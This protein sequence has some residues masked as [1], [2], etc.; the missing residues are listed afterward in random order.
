MLRRYNRLLVAIY[1]AADT[2]SARRGVRPRVSHPV[3]QR[4]DGRHARP[5]AA[6]R[7]SVDRAVHRA[8]RAAGLPA[9]G[10]LPAAARPHARRRLLRRA[11]RQRPRGDRRRRRARSCIQAYYADPALKAIG[12]FEVSRGVWVLFLALNVVFTYTS[13][14]VV[15]DLLRRRWRAGIGLKRVLIVGVGDLGRMVA[16]RILE[17]SELGFQLVGFVDDRAASTDAIGYRGLPLLGTVDQTPDICAQR[18]DRRDLRRAA[19]RRARQDARRRR[20]RDAASAS[21]CTSCPTCCSS[22]RCGR[23]SRT[24]TACRSSASTTCRCAA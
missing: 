14:E 17:H 1:V 21:T 18:E 3:R 20:V 16:D 9:A 24:S 11:R 5:S 6:H 8:A 15:R 4:A 10:A 13:R 12:F 22:S 23:G 7:L 2:L 19:D